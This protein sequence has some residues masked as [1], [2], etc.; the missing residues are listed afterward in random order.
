[1][2]CT[3]VSLQI[4]EGETLGLVGESGCGKSHPG[5][6]ARCRLIEARPREQVLFDEGRTIAAIKG[7]EQMRD[8]RRQMQIIFQDPY[9]SPESP[10]E[11]GEDH[12]RTR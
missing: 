4:Y 9:A 11:R 1:M 8:M 10:H 12:R 7:K 6:A 2:R 3:D 5:P